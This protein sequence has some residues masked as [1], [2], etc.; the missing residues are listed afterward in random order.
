MPVELGL[1]VCILEDPHGFVI[2]HQAMEIQ[3]DDEVAV[4]M[5]EQSQ[6]IRPSL[7]VVSFDKGFHSPSNRQ[8]LE[9]RLDVVTLPKKGRHSAA[10]ASEAANPQEGEDVYDVHSRSA[11]TGLNGVPYREW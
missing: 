2:H 10:D 6:A 1:R 8:R 9:E 7:R 5:V 4:R 11:A 3:T